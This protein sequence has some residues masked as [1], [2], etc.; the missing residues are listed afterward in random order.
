M[1]RFLGWDC[2]N[3]TLAWSHVDIDTTIADKLAHLYDNLKSFS[4]RANGDMPRFL[5]N[6]D[7]YNELLDI[8]NMGLFFTGRFIKYHSC[9]VVDFLN[10]EK[11]CNVSEVN[12]MKKLREFLINS[13]D[14]SID[15]LNSF[16]DGIKTQTIIESQPHTINSTS[17]SISMGLVFYYADFNPEF[18]SPKLKNNIALSDDLEFSKYLD[19]EINNYIAKKGTKPDKQTLKRL[20]YTAR[21]KHSKDNFLY[22]IKVF[23][24]ED[25]IKGIPKSCLDDLADSTM[26]ILAKLIRDKKIR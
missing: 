25:I 6:T 23:G 24:V 5:E 13:K 11:V 15:S 26:E 16:D 19:N 7:N 1:E 22:L 4:D 17:T 9:N 2:A 18:V 21:K 12:R 8:L 14:I 10:G 20:A 3:K